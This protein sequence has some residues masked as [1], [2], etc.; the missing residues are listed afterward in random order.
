MRRDRITVKCR[1]SSVAIL[2]RTPTRPTSNS[3][4]RQP[5]RSR[6]RPRPRSIR[7]ARARQN[8]HSQAP[9]QQLT[10]RVTIRRSP[11]ARACERGANPSPTTC[12][13]VRV[14]S[15]R[16]I[17]L[18]CRAFVVAAT[19]LCPRF[20]TQNLDGK[21]GSPVRVRQRA[22]T[23]RDSSL[24]KH[25]R[26]SCLIELWVVCCEPGKRRTSTSVQTPASQS[27]CTGSRRASSRAR[28][29]TRSPVLLGG[30]W[31]GPAEIVF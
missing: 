30:G 11:A 7:H 19:R 29:S 31:V 25:G 17:P 3:P 14:T 24:R 8:T 5:P 20:P 10:S 4:A 26:K 18:A 27:I 15:P 23:V 16:Q 9:D 21:E 2:E 1:L 13:H 12:V 6:A 28:S 22:S